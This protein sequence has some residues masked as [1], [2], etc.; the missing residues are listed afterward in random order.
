MTTTREDLTQSLTD[1]DWHSL[2]AHLERGGLI[3]VA[4]DLDVIDVGMA[5]ADDDA[6]TVGDWIEAEKLTRP[7]TEQIS[8]WDV[9]RDKLFYCL[10]VSPYVLIQEKPTLFQ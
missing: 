4:D 6:A 3:V 9:T 7:T 1:A 2:R 10:I 8:A 5:V